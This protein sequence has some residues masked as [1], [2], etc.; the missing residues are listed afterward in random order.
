MK[1]PRFLTQICEKSNNG[2]ATALISGFSSVKEI[3]LPHFTF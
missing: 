1:L 3:Q 2:L